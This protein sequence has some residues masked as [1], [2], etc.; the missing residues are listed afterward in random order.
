MGFKQTMWL[1][2]TCMATQMTRAFS[3]GSKALNTCKRTTRKQHD[4]SEREKQEKIN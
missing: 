1:R 4:L 3:S 2:I